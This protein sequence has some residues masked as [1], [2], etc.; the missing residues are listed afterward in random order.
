[1]W[2]RCDLHNHTPPNEQFPAAKWDAG[3][4]VAACVVAGLDVVAITDH[5]CINRADA[6][7]EAADG[8]GLEVVPGVELSTD[9]GHLLVLSPGDQIGRASGRARV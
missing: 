8:T 6:V 9:R 3:S 2:R 7:C 4:Y 1:M 5:N